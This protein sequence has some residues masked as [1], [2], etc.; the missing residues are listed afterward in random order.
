MKIKVTKCTGEEC[1]LKEKCYRYLPLTTKEEVYQT[2]VSIT[3]DI[4]PSA[5]YN[6]KDKKCKFFLLKED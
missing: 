6:E 2:P 4:F 3:V 1:P 5:P